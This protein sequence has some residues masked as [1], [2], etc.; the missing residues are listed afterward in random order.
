[1]NKVLIIIHLDRAD[2][3]LMDNSG[4]MREPTHSF[5]G[6]DIAACVEA[7]THILNRLQ[8]QVDYIDYT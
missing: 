3:Y 8:I 1:M 6:S 2:I 7:L 5:K 4:R